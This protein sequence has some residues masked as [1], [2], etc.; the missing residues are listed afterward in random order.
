M[1]CEVKGRERGSMGRLGLRPTRHISVITASLSVWLRAFARAAARSVLDQRKHVPLAPPKHILVI[2]WDGKLGDAI[3]SSFFFREAIQ[4]GAAVSVVTTADLAVMHR[5]HFGAQH[6]FVVPANP[7]L[8]SL[9]RLLPQLRDVD[10]VVHPVSRIRARELFFLYLLS[11]RNVFSLDDDIG[12]VNGK[13][14]EATASLLFNEKYAH[15]LRQLGAKD[16]DTRYQVPCTVDY[17]RSE[18]RRPRVV[19]NPFASRPDKSISTQKSAHLLGLLSE[20][21]PD[22]DI[23]ILSR[24][25]TRADANAMQDGANRLNVKVLDGVRTLE[26]AVAVVADADLVVSVDTGFVHVADGLEKMLIAICPE[27]DGTFNAWSPRPLPTTRIVRCAQD[28]DQYRRT[29]KKD[30]DN[31]A[32]AAIHDAL[33]W[34]TEPASVARK[35]TMAPA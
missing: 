3:V 35:D 22:W 30:L 23:G 9:L 34:L 13:M 24:P 16:I 15:V 28:S 27:F 25:D 2:R 26:D 5:D 19:F 17:S 12:W 33:D 4:L 21:L 31:F 18:M 14:G 1:F 20:R 7:G 11:P 10:T 32:D 6:V 8:A 29:G